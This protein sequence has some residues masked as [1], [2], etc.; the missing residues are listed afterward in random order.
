MLFHLIEV[1]LYSFGF[2]LWFTVWPNSNW[3]FILV[4]YRI[5]LFL[6]DVYIQLLVGV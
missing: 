4:Q 1:R 2:P 6:S 5:G 3:V